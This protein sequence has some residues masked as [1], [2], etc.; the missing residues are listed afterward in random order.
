MNPEE[1]YPTPEHQGRPRHFRFNAR[2]A[3]LTYSNLEQQGVRDCATWRLDLVAFIISEF[4][5]VYIIHC[6]ESHQDG[7]N[8]VH[9]LVKF[10]RKLDVDGRRFRFRGVNCN[11]QSAKKI[12]AIIRYIQ[13]DGNWDEYGSNE[14]SESISPSTIN[15]FEIA[16]SS[17]YESW[18]NECIMLKLPFGYSEA[19]WN[20]ISK[21]SINTIDE[22]TPIV[23]TMIP[24]LR[25][26]QLPINHKSF[27]LLG[28]AGCG[29]TTY[30]KT[31]CEKPALFVTHL[32]VLKEFNAATHKSIIFDDMDFRHMPRV[33]QIHIVDTENPRAIHRRYGITTIP[34]NITKYF[35]CNEYPFIE[36][37]AIK[38]RTLLINIRSL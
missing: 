22:D 21:K 30:A 33:S 28:P 11:V 35:T 37:A 15:F 16:R 25:T 8:H 2:N 13:K 20:Y 18:I 24:Q 14:K 34:S 17:D 7:N 19:I 36:D 26:Y 12:P 38:R 23:G 29:K 3:F 1:N 5:P 9:C 32:D 6:L 10:G 4:Q 27:I 31:V